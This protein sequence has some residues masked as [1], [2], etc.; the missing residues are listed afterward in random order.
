MKKNKLGWFSCGVTSVMACKIALDIF[1]KDNVTLYYIHIDTAHKDNARFIADC[2]KWFGVKIN[3]IQSTKYKDQ[4]D[5][6][7][8]TGY[9]NG[10]NGARCTLELKK[11][12]RFKLQERLGY[13]TQIFGF[14]YKTDQVNRALRFLDQYPES[15]PIFPLIEAGYDKNHCAALIEQAGIELPAM[16]KLGYENNN[17]IGCVKGGK[18][19]WNKIRVD[20]PETFDRMAETERNAG[21]SCIKNTFLDELDPNAGRKTKQLTPDCGS[22]CD[23]KY[24][25]IEHKLLNKIMG[26]PS[27]ITQLYLNF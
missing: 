15:N 12:L 2:E 4:F 9:V 18:G 7:D 22:F 10:P 3:Y 27:Q 19:Y 21:H 20:F 17:C 14:E 25:E 11:A 26:N 8:D 24:A 1:G 23:I 5:V 16:Y 6:I 13:P